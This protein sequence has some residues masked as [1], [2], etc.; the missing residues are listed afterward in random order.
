MGAARK[1]FGTDGVRGVAGSFLSADLALSLARAATSRLD[2]P[3]RGVLVIRD[4][5]E[6][7]PMLESAVAA[8]IAAAGGR[9]LLGGVLPTPGAPLLIQRYGLAGAVVISASHNPYADNGIKFFGGDAFKLSD[10]VEAAIEAALD[11]RGPAE[12]GTVEPLHGALEDYLRALHERF[13]GLDLSGR[14]IALDCAN[15]AAHR[16]APEIFRRLGAEVTVLADQPDGRNINAGCGSTHLEGLVELMRGGDHDAG[17]ALDGDADRVLAVD[18]NGVVVDG[19]EIIALAATARQAPGVAVT[20]M[21]N[22]GFHT[23][24]EGAGIEV[25][26]TNVGD[27][28]V[29]QALRETGWAL[30]GEQ[31]GHVIDMDFVPS[32]DGTAAALLTL[33]ALGT[34]DLADRH[35]MEKLPQTLVNVRVPD[36]AAFAGAEDV[37]ALIATEH[38]ASRAAAACSSAPPAPSPSSA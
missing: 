20:V 10:D 3:A 26:T 35:A 32:G 38:A 4:T 21:T 1:L 17:F 24:M 33:E 6:S 36:R 16:A 8:G 15:G 7:G 22:Y 2:D 34:T 23:A 28:Y 29:L 14:R 11:E 37:Q 25:R 19:D 31:S 18:R 30:G 5:R 12:M 27:R 9:A 13:A